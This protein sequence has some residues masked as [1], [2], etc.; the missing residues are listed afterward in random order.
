MHH[1]TRGSQELVLLSTSHTLLHLTA[2]MALTLKK[3][4]PQLNNLRLSLSYLIITLHHL[5]T[6][7]PPH[8]F[9]FLSLFNSLSSSLT[10]AGRRTPLASSSLPQGFLLDLSPSLG[11]PCAAPAEL[12][13]VHSLP[14][15]KLGQPAIL[16]Q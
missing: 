9:H 8:T 10:L 12:L 16:R 3:L 6:L 2:P 13:I 1:S 5:F 14:T 11:S 15:H 7:H 4:G